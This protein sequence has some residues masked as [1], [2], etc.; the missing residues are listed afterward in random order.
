M[1]SAVTAQYNGSAP[2]SV[3]HRWQPGQSGNP[4]GK[5]K[6]TKNY[7]VQLQRDLEVAVREHLPIHKVGA[8]IDKLVKMAENGH[9]HAA[10]LLLDKIIPNAVAAQEDAD[11]ASKQIIFR[12]ENATFAAV[13]KKETAAIEGEIVDAEIVENPADIPQDQ[14]TNGN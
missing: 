10:K 4:A 7:I 6:G 5:P 12:I 3:A 13:A 8:I 14:G 9:V 1:S 2:G 11:N